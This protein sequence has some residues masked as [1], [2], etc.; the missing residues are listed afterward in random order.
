L[1]DNLSSSNNKVLFLKTQPKIIAVILDRNQAEAT[2]VKES[3]E[4]NNFLAILLHLSMKLQR[5]ST[6][7]I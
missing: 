7:T 5:V 4:C 6:P 1:H 2:T 3:R